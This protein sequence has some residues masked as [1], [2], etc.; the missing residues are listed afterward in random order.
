MT[1]GKIKTYSV[2]QNYVETLLHILRKVGGRSSRQEVFECMAEELGVSAGERYKENADGSVKFE[3]ALNSTRAFLQEADYMDSSLPGIWAL[4]AK[5]LATLLF[6]DSE[7]MKLQKHIESKGKLQVSVEQVI[8]EDLVVDDEEPENS[9]PR[10]II[11]RR[12]RGKNKVKNA[13]KKKVA[14][15][16]VAKKKVAKKKNSAK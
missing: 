4:T 8:N 3:M 2:T 9:A 6:D 16:K 7:M 10:K 11:K 5:G 1:E 15:K 14:K 13:T 12:K